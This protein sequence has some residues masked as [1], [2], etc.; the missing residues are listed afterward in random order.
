MGWELLS[1]DDKHLSDRLS[2]GRKYM[3]SVGA[4]TAT[5]ANRNLILSIL[6]FLLEGQR[7]TAII[8]DWFL[9]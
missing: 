3:E 2:Q 7:V 8:Q 9:K 6:F 5:T 4:I 1:E